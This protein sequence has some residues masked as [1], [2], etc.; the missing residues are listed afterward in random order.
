MKKYLALSVLSGCSAYYFKTPITWLYNTTVKNPENRLASYNI[1]DMFDHMKWIHNVSKTNTKTLIGFHNKIKNQTQINVNVN[2][3][4]TEF[5][6]RTNCGLITNAITYLN[7]GTKEL[8]YTELNDINK[9]QNSI[10]ITEYNKWYD[11]Y[12]KYLFNKPCWEAGHAISYHKIK[13]NHYIKISSNHNVNTLEDALISSDI[14]TFQDVIT[15]INS[16]KSTPLV[17]LITE[18]NISYRDRYLSVKC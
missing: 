17:S 12:L 1:N 6:N 15:E 11:G 5:E 13:T 2:E 16:Y 4:E 3:F 10:V 14:L 8:K 18:K 7:N 9:N